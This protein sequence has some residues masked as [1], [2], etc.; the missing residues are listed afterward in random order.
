MPLF[1]PLSVVLFAA[2]LTASLVSSEA[3]ASDEPA[4]AS[5]HPRD[6]F[7]RPFALAGYAAGQAGAYGA[8]GVGGRARWEPFPRLGVEVFSEHLAVQWPGGFRHDHPIG[9]NLYAPFAVTETVRV[10][11]LLGFCAVFSF[12]EPEKP[13]GPRA[14]DI[15]FGAHAG[16]GVEIA[17]EDRI[18][19]FF[20][21]QVIGYLSHDRTLH[22]WTGGVGDQLRTLAVFQPATGLQI[23]LGGR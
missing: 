17:I 9:F 4:T 11:P 20:D 12:I 15:L 10:R 18:S 6:A 1:R 21:A 14:D 2:T 8:A 23:H 3:R 5:R 22:G 7:A 19:W 16:M 13:S